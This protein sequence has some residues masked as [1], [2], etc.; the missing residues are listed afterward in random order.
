MDHGL[1]GATGPGADV[2]QLQF[3]GMMVGVVRTELESW[4]AAVGRQE[5][6]A[7]A[8]HYSDNASVVP[9][10]SAFLKGGEAL[11]T[12]SDSVIAH[13]N[14]ANASILDIEVSDG[15]AYAYGA[16][17]FQPSRAGEITGVGQ[18]VTVLRR[19]GEN[20]Q[21]R[22]QF[23]HG[24]KGSRPFASAAAADQPARLE[25]GTTDS[26]QVPRDA[27]IGAV[28]AIAGLRRS[29]QDND[30]P[31][32]RRFFADHA[33][34]LLPQHDTPARGGALDEAIQA[35]MATFASVETIE[36]DFTSSGRLAVLVGELVL[37]A[38]NGESHSG[39]YIAVFAKDGRTWRIRSLVVN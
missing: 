36:L 38:R 32:V 19:T 1:P 13:A 15:I 33:L 2:L 28:T 26:G 11:L 7:L 27:F 21:I 37:E 8:E 31:A 25:L 30:A 18:H 16:F 39:H 6:R 23:F 20:W 5:P 34:L 29:W 9:P 4:A 24:S 35:A 12:F 17:S 22:T 10:G 14:A 3:V